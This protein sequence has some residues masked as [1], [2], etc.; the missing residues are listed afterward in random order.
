MPADLP[1]M[2]AVK[3]EFIINLQTTKT[4]GSASWA[5][6]VRTVPSMTRVTIVVR[7]PVRRI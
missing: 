5:A 3:F 6:V 2:R 4:L 1:M 7:L